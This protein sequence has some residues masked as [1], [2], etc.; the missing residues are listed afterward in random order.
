M[1]K[2]TVA[3]IARIFEDE[4]LEITKV[5]IVKSDYTWFEVELT[6]QVIGY[7]SLKRISE[8]FQATAINMCYTGSSLSMAVH[9]A[10]EEKSD[11][12]F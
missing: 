12:E 2:L 3:N 10:D 7:N 1:E 4:R 9:P 6:H 11:A 8:T 5:K